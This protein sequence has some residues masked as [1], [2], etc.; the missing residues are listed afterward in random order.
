MNPSITVLLH[1]V[2]SLYVV[3]YEYC[4]TL[5]Y[6]IVNIDNINLLRLHYESN[7]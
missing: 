6:F 5:F 3:L 1:R 7:T 2:H 4:F